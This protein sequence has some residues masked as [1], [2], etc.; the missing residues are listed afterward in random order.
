LALSTADG[1]AIS[2]AR[3]EGPADAPVVIVLVH[4]FLNSSRSPLV[5]AFARMLAAR[6]HV[7]TPDL[8]GHGRSGGRVTL[9]ALEP[10]DVD[11]AVGAARAAWPEL[12]VVT[13]GTSLGGIAVLRHAGLMGGVAGTVAISSP[14]Y[15][16]P[17][18]RDGA[19]RLTRFVESRAGR[20]VAARFLRTRV[21]VLPPVDDMAAVGA[22]I[23][24]AFTIVVHDPDEEYFGEEHARAIYDA[25]R[26]PKELW[27][28]P[29]AGHGSDMLTPELADRLLAEVIGRVRVQ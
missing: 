18:T 28:R 7:I 29:G 17:D 4:G 2:A 8:R 12:P 20:Q 10:L 13:V 26:D 5:H 14:A 27:L 3:L 6:V 16:D 22:G 25:A 15:Y 1:V 24:P 23:A 21:G 9:G 11:A 19:R